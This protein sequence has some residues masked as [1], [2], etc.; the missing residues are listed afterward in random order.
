MDHGAAEMTP[1]A[2]HWRILLTVDRIGWNSQQPVTVEQIEAAFKFEVP[3]SELQSAMNA[4]SNPLWDGGDPWLD[5]GQKG[6]YVSGIR[7]DVSID[8]FDSRST[9]GYLALDDARANTTLEQPNAWSWRQE[10][11]TGM[12]WAGHPT[13]IKNAVL[14]AVSKSTMDGENQYGVDDRSQLGRKGGAQ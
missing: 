13:R 12:D 11:L 14:P 10:V 2:L 8:A 6:Y 5:H 1:Q 3:A 4:M 7:G 9:G